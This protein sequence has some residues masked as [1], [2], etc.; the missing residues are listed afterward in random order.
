MLQCSIQHRPPLREV[1][2]PIAAPWRISSPP[3]GAQ[4][5]VVADFAAETEERVAERDGGSVL[6]RDGDL[7]KRRAITLEGLS[8]HT[9]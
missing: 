9:V 4:A 5:S 8:G 7:L 3:T 2:V 1:K 6:T